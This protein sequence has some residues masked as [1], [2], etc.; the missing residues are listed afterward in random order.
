MHVHSSL[1]F[2]TPPRQPPLVSLPLLYKEKQRLE[3]VEDPECRVRLSKS[4]I[5][6]RLEKMVPKLM[7]VNKCKVTKDRNLK[8]QFLKNSTGKLNIVHSTQ[9]LMSETPMRIFL[10]PHSPQKYPPLVAIATSVERDILT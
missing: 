3:S 4:K 1:A 5:C 2:P 10:H 6:F 7:E 9:P 8:K